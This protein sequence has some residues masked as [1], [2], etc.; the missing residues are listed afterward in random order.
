MHNYPLQSDDAWIWLIV[1]RGKETVQICRECQLIMHAASKLEQYSIPLVKDLFSA[2][3]GDNSFYKA[4]NESSEWTERTG[5]FT[6]LDFKQYVVL[7]THKSPFDTTVY[8]LDG[9]YIPGKEFL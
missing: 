9:N 2:F 4:E 6:E 5:Y 7:N 1:E 3:S 8:H